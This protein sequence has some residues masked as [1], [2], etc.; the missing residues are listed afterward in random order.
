MTKCNLGKVKMIVSG[1]NRKY[2]G[3][4]SL[5]QSLCQRGL[6]LTCLRAL[7]SIVSLCCCLCVDCVFGRMNRETRNSREAA[8]D[9][10]ALP[11]VADQAATNSGS[12]MRAPTD[13]VERHQTMINLRHNF[14]PPL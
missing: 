7:Q 14:L 4:L 8:E 6:S 9:A 12:V 3:G 1:H 11:A 2:V 5:C 13:V 10:A